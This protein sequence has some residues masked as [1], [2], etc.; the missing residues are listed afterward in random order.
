M[1]QNAAVMK[2]VIQIPAFNEAATIAATIRDLPRALPGVDEIRV[3]VMDDGSRD[4][5]AEAARSAGADHV[6]RWPKN[7]GLALT[8]RA[9][10]DE[11]LRLGADVI[12]HTDAD[13]QY[14]ARDIA[15]LIAP[16]VEGRADLV[17]GCR[18]MDSIPHFSPLKRR[19]QRWGS[20]AV[21]YLSRTDVPDA[22]SGFRAYSRDAAARLN[23][24]TTY[25]Y[26][27][28]TLIQAG[29]ENIALAFVPIRTNPKTRDSRLIRSNT[30]YIARSIVTLFRIFVLYEPLRAFSTLACLTFAPALAIGVRFVLAYLTGGGQGHI[31]SLILAT[32]LS[33]VSFQLFLFGVVAD[34]LSANRRM[35]AQMLV[36][37]RLDDDSKPGA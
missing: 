15:A 7:R 14:D 32:I 26:T 3:L 19:L 30:H 2:L 12:V 10:L 1:V 21:R 35:L 36:K 33:V 13:N 34:L 11:A 6:I 17:V 4:G 16:I 25:T 37:Q 23:V 18:D 20:R 22:T 8:F 27:L 29:R 24:H 9:G 28:E 31:Q 5:T